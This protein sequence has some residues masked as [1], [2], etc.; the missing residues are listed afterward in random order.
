M[1]FIS[2]SRSRARSLEAL[3]LARDLFPLTNLCVCAGRMNTKTTQRQ[4]DTRVCSVNTMTWVQCACV[5]CEHKDRQRDTHDHSHT[6]T[7]THHTLTLMF[8]QFPSMH[9]H[10][11]VVNRLSSLVKEKKRGKNYAL[12]Y[13]AGKRKMFFLYL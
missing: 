3:Q 2:R 12:F 6:H 10:T 4:S 8:C 13:F 1:N 7:H 9:A 11:Q 5:Q